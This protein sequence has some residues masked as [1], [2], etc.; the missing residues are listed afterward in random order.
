MVIS[1]GLGGPLHPDLF[2]EKL[3][4]WSQTLGNFVFLDGFLDL[5]LPYSV[6]VLVQ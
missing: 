5:N 6:N 3:L 1:L 4:N 2:I